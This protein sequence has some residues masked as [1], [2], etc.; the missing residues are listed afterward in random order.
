MASSPGNKNIPL[1][2]SENIIHVSHAEYFEAL[3]KASLCAARRYCAPTIKLL[4]NVQHAPE[5]LESHHIAM[6]HAPEQKKFTPTWY[7]AQHLGSDNSGSHDIHNIVEEIHPTPKHCKA[8]LDNN[9]AIARENIQNVIGTPENNYKQ[10]SKLRKNLSNPHHFPLYRDLYQGYELHNAFENAPKYFNSL[11]Q[12]ELFETY[13]QKQ[14]CNVLRNWAKT[15]Y[16]FS[17][18]THPQFQKELLTIAQ[19]KHPDV[20]FMLNNVQQ[21]T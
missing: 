17:T 7:I 13:N 12:Q 20:E 5:I 1:V 2:Y 11:E 8:P 3:T 6:D 16:H 21:K 9:N 10:L 4:N 15:R 14:V 19:S 18:G